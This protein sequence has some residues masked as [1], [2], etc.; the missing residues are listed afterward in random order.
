M[1]VHSEVKGSTPEADLLVAEVVEVLLDLA[2]H[3][4][5]FPWF[6]KAHERG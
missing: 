4:M 1:E 6:A 2:V 5:V 3:K